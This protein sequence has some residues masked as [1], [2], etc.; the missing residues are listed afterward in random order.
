MNRRIGWRMCW[1]CVFVFGYLLVLKYELDFVQMA[2]ID[3]IVAFQFPLNH[4]FDMSSCTQKMEYVI[5]DHTSLQFKQWLF[6][7]SLSLCS[8]FFFLLYLLLSLSVIIIFFEFTSIL[9]SHV[10]CSTKILF[11]TVIFDIIKVHQ[12]PKS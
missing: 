8:Q 7:F 9:W 11:F 10:I 12:V 1:V 5:C 2:L 3:W 6:F 4:C